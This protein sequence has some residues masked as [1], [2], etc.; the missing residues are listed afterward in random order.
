MRVVT[1]ARK[2][3]SAPPRA[4]AREVGRRTLSALSRW[5]GRRRDQL[6]PTYSDH[7]PGLARIL[8]RVSAT[9]SGPSGDALAGVCQRYIEHRFD[10]LGSGWT[11]VD[12]GRR[13][14]GT[15]GY[16]FPPGLQVA[17]DGKGSWL[18]GRVNPANLARARQAW[19]LV[20]PGYRPIDWQADFKS[21]YRWAST[22][23]YKDVAYG[24]V[25]GADVK[26][27][28]E[29]AR[30][31]HL[32][33]MALAYGAS[34]G[35]DARFLPAER[36][37]TEAKDQMLDF[38]ATNP[39]RYGVNWRCTMDVAIR[40]T[41][42]L[43]AYD[44][45]RAYGAP[46]DP[47]FEAVFAASVH[48]HARFIASNLE[49]HPVF[50]SNHYLADICGLAFA[51]AYLA[52]GGQPLPLARRW[53]ALATRE[54]LAETAL[55]FHD[56]GGNK[57]GSVCYH[58]LSSEMVV[59]T[60]ALLASVDVLSEPQY[61]DQLARVGR[62]LA[63]T[64]WITK[65][66]AQVPQVGDNDSGRFLAVT[67]LPTQI[68]VGEAKARW[69]NLDGY[70]ELQD[71]DLYW[72]QDSLDHRHLLVVGR[73][74]LEGGKGDSL[75]RVLSAEVSW[76]AAGAGGDET[77]W[78]CRRLWRGTHVP[79]V[80]G[81]GE[82]MGRLTPDK[83]KATGTHDLV[84]WRLM[85]GGRSLIDGLEAVAFPDFGLFVLRSQRLYLAIRCGPVGQAGAGGHSHNDQLGLEVEF[86][87]DPWFRDPGTYLYTPAP[88][89][90]NAYRSAQAHL[91]PRQ[92]SAE[93]GDLGAGL[94]LLP[95]R[96]RARCLWFG[97]EGFAGV[98][99]G[100]G[101][102]T[103]REVRLSDEY[104]VVSDAVPRPD[105]RIRGGNNYGCS[106]S[107]VTNPKELLRLVGSWPPFS[108]GY[109]VV[110]RSGG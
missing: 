21:G 39:P 51:A 15:E 48:D 84:Q 56:D 1:L 28:W 7:G 87:G 3:L 82:D 89:A 25:R 49:W 62:M 94:F 31:Q 11:E 98:H 30:C 90:R 70:D 33:R 91:V 77:V 86:D 93:P 102:P 100:Y 23:W 10:L 108:P 20:S 32:P 109:G 69:A 13:Y 43:V 74:L 8:P 26:V 68:T 99:Y 60:T 80:V 16:A 55:Q 53:L 34:L 81:S 14:R 58:R 54:L 36:Y 106:V 66:S 40:V 4:V 63:F 52:N 72:A 12:Y 18:E 96:A 57:E 35:G 95:E 67:P 65:E 50:R 42:W 75:G 2:G 97:P 45:L 6:F 17:A 73:G 37:L 19:A 64:A 105:G 47:S 46:P 103:V 107:V 92:D 61:R 83:L 71:E 78:M 5:V 76:A 38:I 101:R 59:Y 9:W 27:P 85:P 88:D 104:V 29:L 110:E 44:L 24:V 79:V 22:T 41:N